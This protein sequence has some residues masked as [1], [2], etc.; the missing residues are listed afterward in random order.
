MELSKFKDGIVDFRNSGMK[1]LRTLELNFCFQK[2][3]Q[4]H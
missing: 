3:N 1:E 2:Y 4:E